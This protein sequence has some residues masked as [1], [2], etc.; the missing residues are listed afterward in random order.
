MCVP[1]R[2]LACCGRIRQAL[3]LQRPRAVRSWEGN[4]GALVG[5]QE[6][7][8]NEKMCWSPAISQG[9]GKGDR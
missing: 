1:M 2:E 5:M 4:E 7:Q 6:H 8:A 9:A 3:A